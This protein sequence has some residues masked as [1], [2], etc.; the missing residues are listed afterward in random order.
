M[1]SVTV[2][3][4][5]GEV[6]AWYLQPDD[7]TSAR[8]FHHCQ[9]SAIVMVRDEADMLPGCLRCLGFCDE[10][11]V[12]VDDR[13]IDDSAEI[14]NALGAKV[15]ATAF[16]DFAGM[17]NL[18]TAQSSGRWLLF[19]D[20]DE[21]VS[22]DLALELLEAM[23]SDDIDACRL[24][25]ANVFYGHRMVASGYKERPIRLVRREFSVWRGALHESVTVPR[26]R[27]SDAASPLLHLSHRSVVDNLRK[28]AEWAPLQARQAIDSGATKATAASIGVMAARTFVRHYL[29]GRGWRDR[30]AGFVESIYQ[31][32]SLSMV[33]A[34][35]WELERLPSI[36]QRYES[37]DAAVV[38]LPQAE[39]KATVADIDG[40]RVST[41]RLVLDVGA[42]RGELAAQ[43]I[44]RG[45]SVI[46]VEPD[47][48]LAALAAK[49]TGCVR[50]LGGALPFRDHCFGTITCTEV[51]EHVDDPSL[52]I[53]EFER[54]ADRGAQLR[55]TV[56][57]AR[58]ERA[59]DALHPRY[60]A[61]AGHRRR[62][63]REDLSRLAADHGVSVSTLR[64]THLGP[65]L[66]W[67]MHSILRTDA[68]STGRVPPRRRW[69]DWVA[70]GLI[71][72]LRRLRGT[73]SIVG[74][75]E[76]VL[77][78]SWILEGRFAD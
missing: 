22:A 61:N 21:R 23:A 72:A 51:L 25:I 55:L 73:R 28:T 64:A 41:G 16:S 78:K 15:T 24:P 54:V 36:S 19:V 58:T 47:M 56:P 33:E 13:T 2:A 66:A 27:V 67:L 68:D 17:R 43:L 29:M 69:I 14:A 60:T 65:A 30:T 57:T 74:R 9:L 38:P 1:T 4:T 6:A 46:A 8:K 49:I 35:R 44:A 32:F 53:T 71:G 62:F 45:C 10:V 76:R 37:I 34:H 26:S 39:G 5:D 77:G 50:A 18:A 70:A 31:A 12:V 75:V 11:V 63:E 52:V 40:W 20:A 7:T 42:G 59:F 48:G 3:P